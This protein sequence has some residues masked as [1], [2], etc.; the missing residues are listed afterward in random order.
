MTFHPGATVILIIWHIH[1]KMSAKTLASLFVSF[2]VTE[3]NHLRVEIVEAG[4]LFRWYD[5]P[6]LIN[7]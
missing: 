7:L 6:G 5:A 4:V 3:L 2:V 1:G